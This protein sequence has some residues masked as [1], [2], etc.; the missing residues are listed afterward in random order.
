MY[1]DRIAAA[2][3]AAILEITICHYFFHREN[4]FIGFLDPKT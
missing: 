2:I 3:L 1:L 4:D